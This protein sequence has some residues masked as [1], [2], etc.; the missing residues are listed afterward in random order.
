MNRD[1]QLPLWHWCAVCGRPLL[2]DPFDFDSV[3]GHM[4]CAWATLRWDP[5]VPSEIY[6]YA[7]RA[8]L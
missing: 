2:P 3:V 1:P 5:N 7:R 6:D 8:T 4:A